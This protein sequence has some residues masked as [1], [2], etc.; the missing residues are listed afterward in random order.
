MPRALLKV[1]LS[2]A[3][4]IM[5]FCENS[6]SKVGAQIKTLSHFRACLDLFGV[7]WKS[8]IARHDELLGHADDLSQQ[9]YFVKDCYGL[10]EDNY[11]GAKALIM[12]HIAA[13]TPP[14]ALALPTGIKRLGRPG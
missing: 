11:T 10:T 3:K 14:A 4:N 13:L 2:V 12:D 8:F 7:Y 9:K 1:Q 5:N 6:T